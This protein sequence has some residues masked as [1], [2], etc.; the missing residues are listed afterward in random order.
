[1]Y[2]LHNILNYPNQYTGSFDPIFLF[3]RKK[4]ECCSSLQKLT[5]CYTGQAPTRKTALILSALVSAISDK[6]VLPVLTVEVQGPLWSMDCIGSSPYER[7]KQ[8]LLVHKTNFPF[9][10]ELFL[11]QSKTVGQERQSI[12]FDISS[13]TRRLHGLAGYV[14]FLTCHQLVL[15]PSS[16]QSGSSCRTYDKSYSN[17]RTQ[18][19]NITH[20]IT[21]VQVS[22]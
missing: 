2:I 19:L 5:H 1:M 11:R 15:T 10:E 13:A 6:L 8:N 14:N 4:R 21:L 22:L 7:H 12:A 17:K 9:E 20:H 16:F 3:F 18:T